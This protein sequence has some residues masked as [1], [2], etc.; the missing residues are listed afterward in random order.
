[1][2]LGPTDLFWIGLVP[3]AL[4]AL[5]LWLGAR[6]GVRT[7]AAWSLAVG[8]AIFL[9]MTL[10]HV[11]TSWPTAWDKLLH[12]RV[13]LDWLPWL[14]L[15]A[16]LITAL[17]AC[18]PPTWRRWLVALA[19]AF[20]I[21]VPLR[22]LASNAA[23]MSRWTLGE[24]LGVLAFWSLL[25]AALWTTLALGRRSGQPIVRS[26]LLLVTTAGVA[27]T[28]AASHSITLGEH[29]GVVAAT[30]F[31]AIAAAWWTGQIDAG[32]S[33]AA[34]PIAVALLSLILLGYTY[35]LT[36][37]NAALLTVALAAS[38]GWLPFLPLPWG[39]GRGEGAVKWSWVPIALRIALTLLPLAL[40]AGLAISAA[41]ADPYR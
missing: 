36:A 22:L 11:R 25:L 32:P 41:M 4:A 38:A 21:A 28:L 16:A 5:A 17:A 20:T 19:A 34:G 2:L 30:L 35:D 7:T 15:V 26:A 6:C 3:C 40:A 18:A 13:G 10:Q 9:G 24:K 23:A 33:R 37:T 1:M 39:E 12:P 31:G 29:A 8:G 27:L 14:V